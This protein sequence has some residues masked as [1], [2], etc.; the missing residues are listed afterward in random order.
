LAPARPFSSLGVVNVSKPINR[1]LLTTKL[2][3]FASGLTSTEKTVLLAIAEHLGKKKVAWPSYSTIAHYAGTNRSTAYRTIDKLKERKLLEV[4]EAGG[5]NSSNQY[6]IDTR[7]LA[8]LIT[9]NQYRKRAVEYLKRLGTEQAEVVAG[10]NQGG[11]P[12]QPE[13]PTQRPSETTVKS[14]Q[15]KNACAGMGSDICNEDDFHDVEF[16]LGVTDRCR[17][18]R[19]PVK[20]TPLQAASAKATR[21]VNRC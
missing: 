8:R 3:F 13:R 20:V 17:V 15:C 4:I 14:Q 16:I 1:S 19:Q 10:R 21:S 2:I 5:S 9:D 6:E 7:A 12:V 11:C 18:H